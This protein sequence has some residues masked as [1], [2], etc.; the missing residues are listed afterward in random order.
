LEV[1]ISL[2]AEA[3]LNRQLTEVRGKADP[4][5]RALDAAEK[6]EAALEANETSAQRA[7]QAVERQN[8]QLQLDLA[9]KQEAFESLRRRIEDDFGLVQ[10]EYE[11][12]MEGAVPLPLGELVETLPAVTILAADTEEN[13][14]RKGQLRAW[15][16]N[17]CPAGTRAL[18]ASTCLFVIV[19]PREAKPIA[20]DRRAR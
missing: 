7:L 8:S 14:C 9:R 4:A 16:I 1:T 3:E 2:R 20:S 18:S 15:A 17:R 10:F 19:D 6:N 5:E 12:A 13:C 11:V